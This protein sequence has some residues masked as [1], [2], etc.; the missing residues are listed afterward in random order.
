MLSGHQAVPLS[1]ACSQ[2]LEF[3]DDV[4][5]DRQHVLDET[6]S[7][8]YPAVVAQSLGLS[9]QQRR[10]SWCLAILLLAMLC[11][12]PL[13][14]ISIAVVGLELNPIAPA[15]QLGTNSSVSQ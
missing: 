13:T 4:D 11:R 1:H 3:E 9:R 12:P 8:P 5:K 15:E 6:L 2:D 7:L 14:A 10:L